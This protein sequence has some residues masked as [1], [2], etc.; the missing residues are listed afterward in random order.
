MPCALAQHPA[1]ADV[2]TLGVL[3]DDDEVVRLRVTGSS[4]DERSLV[5]VQVQVE[6]HLQQQ[7]ALDDTG[8]H[9]GCTDRAQQ[10]RVEPAQLV[11]H[12]VAEDLAVA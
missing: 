3:A 11:E 9:L 12:R 10:D 6:P 2:G 5:H 1:L 8:R 7:P 4:A